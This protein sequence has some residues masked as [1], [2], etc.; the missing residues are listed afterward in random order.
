VTFKSKLATRVLNSQFSPERTV[1]QVRKLAQEVDDLEAQRKEYE[2]ILQRV[3][4]LLGKIS[5]SQLHPDAYTAFEYARAVLD[6]YNKY[7]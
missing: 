6:A 2:R 4:K 7:E 3:C 5:K 1:G